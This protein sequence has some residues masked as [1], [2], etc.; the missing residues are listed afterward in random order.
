[1]SAEEEQHDL[2]F[3]GPLHRRL[4]ERAQST[5]TKHSPL[6]RQGL[7]HIDAHFARVARLEQVNVLE[8]DGAIRELGEINAD[9]HHFAAVTSHCTGT[10]G[11][12]LVVERSSAGS[13]SFLPSGNAVAS[14]VCNMCPNTELKALV[15]PVLRVPDALVSVV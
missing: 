1:M 9:V 12:R 3:I 6:H 14:N 5:R 15:V 2:M 10:S 7:I 11:R 4:T 8:A 13:G